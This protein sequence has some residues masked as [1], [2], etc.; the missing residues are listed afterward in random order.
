[1]P[2]GYFTYSK[3]IFLLFQGEGGNVKPYK[4]HLER[5]GMTNTLPSE[6]IEI[7]GMTKEETIVKMQ[8]LEDKVN[9]EFESSGKSTLVHAYCSGRAAL[10]DQMLHIKYIG[11]KDFYPIEAKLK[12]LCGGS[13]AVVWACFDCD[14][15][16]Q[17]D[18]E[19]AGQARNDDED[20]TG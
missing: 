15:N 10:L 14:R 8:E 17:L 5:L 6:F 7:K 2:K 13:N 18:Q 9:T 4:K 20:L 12:H 3:I 1:M 19:A 11:V 16:L